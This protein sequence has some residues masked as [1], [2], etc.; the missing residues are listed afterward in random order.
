LKP[1]Q[2]RTIMR[3]VGAAVSNWRQTASNQGLSKTEIERMAS[4]FEHAD[5]QAAT[6]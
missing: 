1:S 4:A 6:G 2:A 3:E 5:L